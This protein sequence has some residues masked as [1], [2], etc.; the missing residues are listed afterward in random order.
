MR[1]ADKR[2]AAAAAADE[3][4]RDAV[5]AA[6]YQPSQHELAWEERRKVW[7]TPKSRSRSAVDDDNNVNAAATR[8]NTTA[9]VGRL[10]RI[11]HPET[12]AEAKAADAIIAGIVR[13]MADKTQ[14]KDPM[15][16][17]VLVK[18]L[19]ASWLRDGTI[20]QQ[21]LDEAAASDIAGQL[22]SVS[23]GA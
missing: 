2:V 17:G 14:F 5:A 11:L 20:T 18:L 15:P 13:R 23:Q 21:M 4:Q 6:R 16:L 10:N 19:Y 3:D 22:Q 9:A 7:L 12:D 1:E 8:N